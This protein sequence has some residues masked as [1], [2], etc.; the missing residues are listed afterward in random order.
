MSY[1]IDSN[2]SKEFQFGSVKPIAPA[3]MTEELRV[4][5][6][7]KKKNQ[8]LAAV[9]GVGSCNP[10]AAITNFCRHRLKFD[11]LFDIKEIPSNNSGE[12]DY[13]VKVWFPD[14]ADCK[15]E[16]IAKYLH[17]RKK[18]AKEQA[19]RLALDKI[20]KDQDLLG[21]YIEVALTRADN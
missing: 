10:I 1:S 5:E 14:I 19:A 15:A 9:P 16:P 21:K 20:N 3:V 13:E 12:L 11:I 6:L 7:R 8:I 17:S 4:V 2:E 18:Y